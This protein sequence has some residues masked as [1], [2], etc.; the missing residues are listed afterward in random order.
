MNLCAI[1]LPWGLYRYKQLTMVVTNSSDI[2]QQKINYL[3][4]GF[5]F[6]G[7]NIDNILV[8]IKVYWTDC[9]KKLELTLNKLKQKGLNCNTEISFFVRT[10][11]GYLGFWVSRYGVKPKDKIPSNKNMKPPISQKE[12]CQ[13]MGVVN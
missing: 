6:I 13:F 2:F 9:L 11:M 12:V 5:E 10:E 4:H 3:F 8:L 7:A 1:F